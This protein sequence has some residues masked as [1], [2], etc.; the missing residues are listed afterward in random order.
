VFIRKI[1]LYLGRYI[2]ITTNNTYAYESHYKSFPVFGGMGGVLSGCAQKS[3]ISDLQQQIN[4]LKSDQIQTISGQIS[5]ISNSITSLQST[6]N[7]LKE[8]I[9]K[10][11]TQASNLE[12]KS[13]ILAD[14]IAKVKAELQGEISAANSETLKKLQELKN[15]VD[16]ELT[17]L[18]AA[19][20][21]LQDKDTDL[22]GQMDSLKI[23]IDTKLK[24]AK[25]WAD[26]TFATLTEYNI[27]AKAV[28]TLQMQVES[29]D[30]KIA[31]TADSTS[32]KLTEAYTAAISEAITNA[33]T[34]MENWVNEKMAGVY[35]AAVIKSKLDSL[36]AG[37]KDKMDR[38]DAKLEALI[39]DNAQEI[40]DLQHD[41]AEQMAEMETAYKAAITEAINYNDGTVTKTI[42]EA[43][44]DVNAKLKALDTRLT[45]LE[46]SVDDLTLRVDS[47]ENGLAKLS[48]ITYIPKYADGIER[49]TYE[50]LY[51]F[52]D[53]AKANNL[54]L[55]FDVYPAVCAD[56]IATAYE[57]NHEIL[58]ARAVY[59]LTK[60]S[61]G[62]FIGLG[63]SNVKSEGDGVLTLTVDPNGL[64]YDFIVG[65]LE[66]SVVIKV[67]TGYSNI[68][69]DY[70]RLKPDG[71]NLAFIQALYRQIDKDKDGKFDLELSQVKEL[72]L[73]GCG[74][75]SLT[76]DDIGL[77]Y[78]LET[79][80]LCDNPDLK[81]INFSNQ[82]FLTKVICTSPD[83]LINCSTLYCRKCTLF[84]TPDG[85]Q[86]KPEDYEVEI[87]GKVWKRY[88]VGAIFGDIYGKQ[89]TFGEANSI[90]SPVCPTGY[91]VPS[92]AEL[93]SLAANFSELSTYQGPKGRWFSG[94]KEY[95][96]ET[97]AIFLTYNLEELSSNL[98]LDAGGYWSSSEEERST[99]YAYSLSFNGTT[100]TIHSYFNKSHKLGVRC[101]KD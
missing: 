36:G 83:A 11:T 67:T 6:D 39:D 66:A 95:S 97:S 65:D 93:E 3:D 99:S 61:A 77:L 78:R 31:A 27:T 54:I 85:K 51:S 80:N 4:S 29:L 76:M 7:E 64:D 71:D 69:S 59:T 9:T 28:A 35:D 89:M 55:R 23:Y 30:A 63:I 24:N 17:I 88:N 46:K 75:T 14:S 56:S 72:D 53:E 74:L 73:S 26:A 42:H 94:S 37:L 60:A 58:S 40:A 79:L 101:V 32:K 100:V 86:I 20:K 33:R 21:A 8:Y 62:D 98:G 43:L 81:S 90:E 96:N 47:I 50:Q 15:D 45:A 44:D 1:F 19:I 48:S 12:T 52:Y 18:R 2:H 49:V 16:E 22:Q 68:Q 5:A 70:I 82:G 91:H 13:K 34:S 87:D 92:K 38:Q 57:K 25:D 10:L 84:Y 41:L